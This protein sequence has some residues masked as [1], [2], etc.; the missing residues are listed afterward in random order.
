MQTENLEEEIYE[1]IVDLC[2]VLYQYGYRTV[3]M[4]A[5]MRI[6]GV[7]EEE[8]MLHDNE[9]FELDVSFEEI[10][11]QRQAENTDQSMYRP[12]DATLH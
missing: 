6:I 7:E 11:E 10:M 12:P 2:S 5:M 8:A 4:G 3:P 9:L 1:L